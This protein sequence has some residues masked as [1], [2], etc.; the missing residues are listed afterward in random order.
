MPHPGLAVEPGL[1]GAGSRRPLNAK[2]PGRRDLRAWAGLG[3]EQTDEEIAEEEP[4]GEELLLLMPESWRELRQLP[5]RVC[6][7]LEAAE[8]GG[9][10][11]ATSLLDFWGLAWSPGKAAPPWPARPPGS[12]KFDAERVAGVRRLAV[13]VWNRYQLHA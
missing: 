2:E 12:A 6:G 4:G 7:L 1:H 5:E 11:A 3:D 8:L 10:A 13:E 9:F